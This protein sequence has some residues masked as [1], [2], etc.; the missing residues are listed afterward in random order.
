MVWP[1]LSTGR[2]RDISTDCKTASEISHFQRYFYQTQDPELAVRKTM[3]TAGEAMFF[4]CAILSTAFFVYAFAT[5]VNLRNFGILTGMCILIAA[6]AD[7]FL[8]PSLMYLYG[9]HKLKNAVKGE[10]QVFT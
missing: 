3:A 9:K 10:R 8:N 6:S 2:G 5:M 1:F 7:A 4:T